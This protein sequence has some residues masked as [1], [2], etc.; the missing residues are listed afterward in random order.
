MRVAGYTQG[1]WKDPLGFEGITLVNTAMLLGIDADGA[2]ELGLGASM[3]F[4]LSGPGKT[5][6]VKKQAARPPKEQ[7]A[8]RAKLA[9][10]QKQLDNAASTDKVATGT[11]FI[12][13]IN[14]AASGVPIPKKLGISFKSSVVSI[15]ATMDI[16][17]LFL[18]GLMTGPGADALVN[19][20]KP[21]EKLILESI[22][23]G[24]SP[25]PNPC[26]ACQL[27]HCHM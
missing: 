26:W 11:A 10:L 6:K 13:N 15:P 12:V 16:F 22:R 14:F 17:D 24:F 27:H 23:A 2:L 4:D 20:M 5:V 9:K 7:S 8:I 21:G 19:A 18:K 3:E 25:K 1:K